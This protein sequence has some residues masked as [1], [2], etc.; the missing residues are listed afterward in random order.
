MA[1]TSVIK[2][3]SQRSPHGEM[4]QKYLAS[5]ISLAMRLWEN[6]APGPRQK[7]VRRPYETVGYVLRGKAEL[8]LEGGQ[9]IVLNPGDSWVVP[10]DEEHAYRILETFTAIEATHPPAQMHDRDASARA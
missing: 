7:S 6:E 5:G 8:H 9:M 4:G 2:V 3:S 10:K 1:D